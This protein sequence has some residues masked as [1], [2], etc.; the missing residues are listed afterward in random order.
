MY[1]Y[2]LMFLI[3]SLNTPTE[4]FDIKDFIPFNTSSTRSGSQHPRTLSTNHHYFYF[5]RIVRLWNH[6]SVID[7]SL[8]SHVIIAKPHKILWNHFTTNFN[9]DDSCTY[10][11]LCPCYRCSRQ[12]TSSNFHNLISATDTNNHLITNM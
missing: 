10:R 11:Y 2:E 12:P 7:I 8:P 5:N 4:N 3:K 1:I 9:S 6:M